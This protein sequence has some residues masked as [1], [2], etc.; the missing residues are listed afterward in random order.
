MHAA[1]I[2][3]VA[4]SKEPR[5]YHVD[6]SMACCHLIVHLTASR[7][8]YSSLH[9]MANPLVP[10]EKSGQAV[11]SR[12]MSVANLQISRSLATQPAEHAHQMPQT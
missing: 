2:G 12:S 10:L 3:S 6:C 7:W 8:A 11:G 9:G 5:T 1:C 4:W